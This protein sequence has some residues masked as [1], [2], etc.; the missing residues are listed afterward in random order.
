MDFNQVHCRS[1]SYKC[2]YKVY[3]R[4]IHNECTSQNNLNIYKYNMHLQEALTH[5]AKDED[6]IARETTSI[7]SKLR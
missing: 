5:A 1:M 3:S 4:E 6:F 7:S 2:I